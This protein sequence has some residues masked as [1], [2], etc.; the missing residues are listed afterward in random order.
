MT[1]PEYIARFIEEARSLGIPVALNTMVTELTRQKHFIAIGERVGL[2]EVAAKAVILAMGCRERTRGAIGIPGPR[3]AGVYTAGA[4][5]R[6]LNIEG[7]M[8]GRKVVIVGSGDIGL[9]MARRL[10]LEGAKVLAVVEM[11]PYPGG[12]TRNV[13]QCLQDFGIP[14]HLNTLVTEIHGRRRVEGVTIAQRGPKGGPI[15]GSERRIHCD[16]LLISAGLIPENELS[17]QAGV[18]LD[19]STR[20]PVVDQDM[21]TLVPGI[22]ACGDVAYVHNLVDWVTADGEAA[23]S[24]A[25]RLVLGERLERCAP[26]PVRPGKG[27]QCVMPHRFTRIAP[28]GLVISLRPEMTARDVKVKFLDETRKTIHMVS[29]KIVRPAEIFDVSLPW[30]I[31][32]GCNAVHVEIT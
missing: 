2:L 1:G 31:L 25:A 18:A 24:A 27:V 13:V 16:T 4:A 23:G 3:P 20:G 5:Q 10:T 11:M 32:G 7:L 14:L 17:Q 6:M 12:L 30:E 29:R 21:E 9:I 19:P 28:E 8:P 15:P 26:I 22:F